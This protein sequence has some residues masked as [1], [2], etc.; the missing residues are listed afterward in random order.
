MRLPA[1][2]S[3]AEADLGRAALPIAL[4]SRRAELELARLNDKTR[5]Q[6]S[7]DL[8][9]RATGGPGRANVRL[10]ATQGENPLEPHRDSDHETR[11][12]RTPLE[13][14]RGKPADP[15]SQPRIASHR[16]RVRHRR[17]EPNPV[18]RTN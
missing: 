14:I 4:T 18:E 15:D 9:T 7:L 8:V 10:Y 16:S 13:A 17:A 1:T 3:P 6:E 12:N 5:R 2:S 11:P